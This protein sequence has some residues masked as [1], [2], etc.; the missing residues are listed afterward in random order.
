MAR[1]IQVSKKTLQI[2][3]SA[4]QTEA[5]DWTIQEKPEA[6]QTIPH[7]HLHIVPRISGDLGQAG[8]WYPLLQKNDAVVVES[9]HRPRLHAD[10]MGAIVAMLR[11]KAADLFGYD[12]GV[13]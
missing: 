13:T 3:L 2:L 5:F 7:L 10:E 1:F 12:C 6:G 4:F 9:M 11:H 8:D